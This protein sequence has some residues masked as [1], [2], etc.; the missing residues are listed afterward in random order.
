MKTKSV[1]IIILLSVKMNA[2]YFSG[3]GIFPLDKSFTF[4]KEDSGFFKIPD[5]SIWMKTFMGKAGLINNDLSPSM[6]TDTNS[7]N[8]KEGTFYFDL[9]IPNTMIVGN[10]GVYSGWN[11]YYPESAF[12]VLWNFNIVIKHKYNITDNSLGYIM[13]REKSSNQFD[14]LPTVAYNYLSISERCDNSTFM[15]CSYEYSGSPHFFTGVDNEE[16]FYTGFFYEFI[17]VKKTDEINNQ[18]EYLNDSTTFRFMYHS[19]D[20]TVGGP[21][22]IINQITVTTYICTT[23]CPGGINEGLNP[24]DVVIYPNPVRNTLKVE[25]KEN[26]PDNLNFRLT[27]ILAQEFNVPWRKLE[28]VYEFDLIGLEKGFYIL[29]ITADRTTYAGEF[30]K[31]E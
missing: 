4:S 19:P 3:E 14:T 5:S 27:N 23:N 11:E 15:G 18:N 17:P 30:V 31:I 28:N 22:W 29:L 9:K 2:Q 13:F 8:V 21:G 6:I 12:N 26:I 20:S 24:G 25:I 7:N 10:A 1:L 16:W